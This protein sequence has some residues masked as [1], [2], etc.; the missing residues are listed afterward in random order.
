VGERRRAW[1]IFG[2]MALMYCFS[3]FYRV[4]TALIAVDLA[5][6]FALGPDQLALLGGMFF[7]A[8]AVT[9]LPLG[10][11]LDRWGAKVIVVGGAL[12]GA[13][14]SAVF[15]LA[16]SWTALLAARALMGLG[17]APVLMGALKLLAEWF[18]PGAFGTVSG[19]ILSLGTVGAL[20]AATPLAGLVAWLGWRGTFLAFAVSTV[21]AGAAI[22]AT[23]RERPGGSLPAPG[24]GAG[25][26]S[27][28]LRVLA[29]PSFW[30]TAPLALVGYASVASLQ[31]LWAGPYFMEALSYT[32]AETGNILLGLGVATAVGSFAGGWLSDRVGSRKWVVVGGNAVAVACFLPLA[33]FGAPSSAAGWTA[34]MSVLGFFSAFRVLLYAHVKESVPRHL[35]GTAVTAINFFI[36]VGPALV[37][38]AMGRVLEA[39]SGDYR[40]AFL[41]PLVCLGLGSGIYLFSRDSRP[42]G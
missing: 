16:E 41:F 18:P 2:V 26:G 12:V 9:Q 32:R 4:S 22:H 8:F 13:A 3:Q 21:L 30:A 1:A 25:E 5:A 38:Q 37:Q 19:L 15:A 36:M 28:L 34:V 20:L 17:M 39:S 42:S 6:E 24:P 33:G 14:G 11:A 7:Y 31:G 27:G 40:A 10:P 35:V 29:I 23:V